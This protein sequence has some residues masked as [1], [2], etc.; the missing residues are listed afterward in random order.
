MECNFMIRT[1]YALLH[2]SPDSTHP[3][4]YHSQLI[5]TFFFFFFVIYCGQL[6]QLITVYF[7]FFLFFLFISMVCSFLI[8]EMQVVKEFI[9]ISN[10]TKK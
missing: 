10:D 4:D 5:P 6:F 7:A 9:F 3:V 2:L 1:F 8:N